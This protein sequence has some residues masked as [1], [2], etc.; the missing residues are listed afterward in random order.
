MNKK[1]PMISARNARWARIVLAVAA[2]SLNDEAADDAT[3]RI[4]DD[5]CRLAEFYYGEIM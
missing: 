5:R 3:K 2:I 1:T 4:G